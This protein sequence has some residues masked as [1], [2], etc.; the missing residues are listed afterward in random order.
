MQCLKEMKLFKPAGKQILTPQVQIPSHIFADKEQGENGYARLS[1]IF[2][3]H[4]VTP[5]SLEDYEAS[6][7]TFS[8]LTSE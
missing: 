2:R 4:K 1:S 7:S 5:F 3:K 6:L 8:K